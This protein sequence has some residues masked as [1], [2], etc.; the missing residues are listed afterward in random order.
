MKV[1]NRLK[2]HIAFLLALACLAF[3]ACQPSSENLP[4]ESTLDRIE[5]QGVVRVGY[6]NEAPY[7]YMDSAERRLTGE[8]PEII[9]HVMSELGVTEVEG[10]LTEFGA[11]IPGLKANRFDVIAAGMYVTPARC[12][13]IAFSDPTYSIGEAFIVEKGNPLDLHSYEDVAN[14]ESATIGVMAGAVEHGYARDIGVPENRIIVFPDNV[15]GL[16]GVKAGRVDAFAATSLT[17]QDI[18]N[19]AGDEDVEKAD[20]FTD[21]II[22]GESIRGY[23]AFGVRPEDTELLAAIN[24]VLADYIGSPEHLELVKPFGFTEANDPGGKTAA[25][26]CGM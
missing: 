16:D 12:E 17:V 6:A 21:P 13:Q 23:G 18:L 7:A 24:G 2:P 11:L 19:K 20:P 9:R 26:L 1:F 15:S 10:V 4:G 8:A 5:R 3:P 14:H 25:E 22:D